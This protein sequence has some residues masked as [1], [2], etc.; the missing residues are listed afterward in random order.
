MQTR[1]S[2][3]EVLVIGT[4][5]QTLAALVRAIRQAGGRGRT[6]VD[7]AAARARCLARGRVDLLVVAPD[8]KPAFADR[9]A[10]ALRDLDTRL[11]IVVFGREMLRHGAPSGVHRIAELHP[12]SRAGLGALRRHVA[13]CGAAE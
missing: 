7:L 10:R 4:A 12:T 5:R 13:A 2:P 6:V 3:P 9:V 1:A 11:E 8:A